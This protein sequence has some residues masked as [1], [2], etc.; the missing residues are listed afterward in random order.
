[1]RRFVIGGP[2]G[3]T[4]LTGRK[5][6]HLSILMEEWQD[7]VEVHSLVKTPSKVDRSAAY[8]T[9]YIAEEHCC[10]RYVHVSVLKSS[11]LMQL[12]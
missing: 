12:V 7:M 1:M 10:S 5:A 6:N 3:D 9:R 2:H 11:Y 8:I 4:G